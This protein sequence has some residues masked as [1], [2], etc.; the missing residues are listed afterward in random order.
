[1]K[2]EQMKIEDYLQFLNEEIHSTVFSTVDNDG[3]PMSRVIDIMLVKENKLYFLT[4][5]T[6]P[7]YIQLLEKPYVSI[8]G[9]KGEDSMSSVSITVN[10]E[11]REVGTKYLDEIFDKNAYMN[12]I[13]ETEESKK[14]LRVFEVYKGT[15]SVFDLGTKP[16]YQNSFVINE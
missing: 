13:Y 6:K 1:M 7:F 8:T 15:V 3:K 16:I 10:G 12:E 5:T 4:A 11:V 2:H 9:M 14:I